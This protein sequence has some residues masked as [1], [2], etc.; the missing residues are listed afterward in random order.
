MRPHRAVF[1]GAAVIGVAIFAIAMTPG[2]NARTPAR[3]GAKAL[4]TT[5]PIAA[6]QR[7]VDL[8]KDRVNRPQAV[9]VRSG[10]TRKDAAIVSPA[11]DAAPKSTRPIDPAEVAEMLEAHYTSEL[12]DP[13]WSDKVRAELS[14][15]LGVQ[16]SGTT[17]SSVQCTTSLCKVA[18][19]HETIDVQK[20]L[21]NRVAGLPV[22]SA[23]VFYRYDDSARPPRTVLYVVREGRDIRGLLAAP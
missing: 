11:S 14:A 5:D 12:A 23:G 21:A 18:V 3:V 13:V 6:L 22:L 16:H 15:A 4:T 17:M 19:L 8:L 1:L 20:D 2:K 10:Q 7:E 9:L